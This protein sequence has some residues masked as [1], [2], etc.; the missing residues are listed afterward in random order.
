MLYSPSRLILNF[1]GP[2]GVVESDDVLE[3]LVVGDVVTGRLA[4][5]LVAFATEPENIDAQLLL[6]LARHG[7]NVVADQAHRAGGK[8][9]DG[10]RFKIS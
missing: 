10:F 9:A 7:M 1:S 2:V 4:D 8:D 3:Q 6:H 5:P